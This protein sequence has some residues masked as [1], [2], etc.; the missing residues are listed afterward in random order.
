MKGYLRVVLL[1]LIIGP[2]GP[3]F[4]A[5]FT[6]ESYVASVITVLHIHADAIENLNTHRIK[7]SNNLVRHAAALEDTF[8]LLG[9]MDWH[10]AQSVT[11]MNEKD[12]SKEEENRARFEELQKRATYALKNLVVAAH[13]TLEEGE[14]ERLTEALAR[15][16]QACNNCHTYLPADV[17]PDVWGNLKRK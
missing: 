10:A 7:Y 9:P 17:A 13:Q 14:H 2:G 11:L 1:V 5:E 15:V 3:L 4:G 6:K 12:P 8:G 16:K